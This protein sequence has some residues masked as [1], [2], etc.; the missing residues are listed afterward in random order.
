MHLGPLIVDF[1]AVCTFCHTLE[2]SVEYHGA[3]S[4]E[5]NNSSVSQPTLGMIQKEHIEV[6]D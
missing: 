6:S 1:H 4:R 2:A 5:L 3:V